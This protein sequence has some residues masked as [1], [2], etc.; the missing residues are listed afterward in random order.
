MLLAGGGALGAAGLAV[1]LLHEP[2]PAP[3]LVTL[4]L[5]EPAT[6]LLLVHGDEERRLELTGRWTEP[7][8]PGDYLLRLPD[9]NELRR[10]VPERF[11]VQ[12][13]KPETVRLRLVG[14]VRR[15]ADHSAGGTPW[16]PAARA[17]SPPVVIAAS[18][19]GIPAPTARR[20]FSTAPGRRCGRWR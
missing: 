19:G 13:S 15:S 6:A 2:P 20:R 12:P 11:V 17:W 18:A 4:E 8:A 14:E 5:D 1:W 7:L 16:R 3:G 10:P 9:P